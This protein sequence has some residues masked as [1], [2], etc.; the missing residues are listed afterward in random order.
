MSEALDKAV[1]AAMRE[2]ARRAILPRFSP[3][4][5]IHADYKSVG[6]AVTAADR[7]SEEILT[8]LLAGL[9]PGAKIIGEEAVSQ[10]PGLGEELGKGTCW[11]LDPLDGTGNFAQGSVPF[12][13]LVALAHDAEPVAGWILD[14]VSNRLC[15]AERGRGARIDGERFVCPLPSPTAR[16]KVAITRL[17]A[18]PLYRQGLVDVLSASCGVLDS[19]RCAADQYPRV[20]TGDN[21]A[22][23]FTRTIS[24][25]HAAGVIFLEEA[26]GVARRQD[27]RSYRCDEDDD[28][29]VVASHP[30]RWEAVT[31]LL[32]DAGITLAR[33]HLH[34][35]LREGR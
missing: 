8:S 12:G 23:L 13:M 1:S 7:E 6:E 10:D 34:R 25:D 28:G 35:E 20:A 22:T 4:R 21:D 3:G 2:A 18:D 17:F 14:P 26:G 33:A 15:S 11:I 27:G 9:I 32:D 16:P 19:P 5:A 29:L 31:R 30:S 24:W